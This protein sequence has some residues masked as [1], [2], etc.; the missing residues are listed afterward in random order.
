MHEP[1]TSAIAAG[2][3]VGDVRHTE[4]R[5]SEHG[6]AGHNPHGHDGAEH[7]S[8]PSM[9]IKVFVALCVLTSAS[10]LTYTTYWQE[11]VPME[12]GRAV[13]LAV[14]VTK[15][16]LVVAFFMH[17]WWESKWKY[18]VTFPALLVSALLCTALVPDIG[19]RTREYDAARLLNAPEA[20]PY[21]VGRE[22]R[23]AQPVVSDTDVHSGGHSEGTAP[24]S[25]AAQSP[26][27]DG[28]EAVAPG[29]PH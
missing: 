12:V 11:N 1:S 23:V 21:T 17:L 15:A 28:H 29:E 18:V 26:A 6:H 22:L 4:H 7:V 8:V 20:M 14:S 24:S 25:G 16:F 2:P 5:H 10:L 3:A 9:A 27:R 19:M 13:M